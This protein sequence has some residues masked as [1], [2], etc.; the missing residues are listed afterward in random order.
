M[1][2]YIEKL[3]QGRVLVCGDVMLDRYYK[4]TT[5]RISP[6]GPVAVVQIRDTEERAGGAGNVSL[7]IASLGGISSI[8][9]LVGIDDAASSLEN[10]LTNKNVDCHF[11]SSSE[12]PTI[13]K[14]RVLSQN[15]QLIRLDWEETDK[16]IDNE[17]LYAHYSKCLNH[18]DSVILSDYAKGTL[19]GAQNL[20]ELARN[21]NKT[22]LVDPKGTDF[23]KYRNASVLTPNM[24]EFEAVAGKSRTED[25]FL[26]KALLLTEKLE[27]EAML[28]TRSEKGMTLIE[29]QGGIHTYPTQAKQVFDVTGAGDTVIGTLGLA[30]ACGTPLST[31]VNLANAAAGIVVGKV[32]TAT[33]TPR[34]LAEAI[35][36]VQPRAKFGLVDEGDLKQWVKESRDAGMTIVMT[37][38]CFDVLHPGHV[39]Y[40]EEAKNLGDRLIIALNDDDSI[41][42]LKGEKRP[43]NQLKD[44]AHVLAGLKSVDWVVPFSEDTPERIIGEILP[45]ILVKGGDYKPEDLAGGKAVLANGGKVSTLKFIEGC[46]TTSIIDKIVNSQ[47]D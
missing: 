9:G 24:K 25:E 4:G 22:V 2:E 38:G 20:I 3:K 19:N 32:G 27:L 8:V 37:N 43:I 23:S 14:L 7:N 33:V 13:T 15:Q 26:D 47:K 30:L 39:A 10:I 42:R 12:V 18:V 16:H 35:T 17:Q 11:V 28:V 41:R 34:E 46:S 40:L 21:S 36:N 6:E 31:A 1:I 45:S 29:R 44:R 5:E